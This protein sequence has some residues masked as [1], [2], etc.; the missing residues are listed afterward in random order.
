M[1]RRLPQAGFT[2]AELLGGLAIAAI[3]L[4]PL[5][6]MLRSGTE[7][8][9]SVRSAL[10]LNDDARF[11]LGRIAACATAVM[12]ACEPAVKAALPSGATAAPA[13]WLAPFSYAPVG[14][15]LVETDASVA[16]P[17]KSIVASNVKAFSL[18]APEVVDGFPVLVAELTLSADGNTVTRTRTMRVGVRK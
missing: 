7:S 11:A 3:L 18:T 14:T 4:L 6:D 8:A 1:N 2:L 13:T 12:A 16:P 10:A 5:A 17:R 15:D 9:R